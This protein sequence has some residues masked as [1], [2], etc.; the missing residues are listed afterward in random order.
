MVGEGVRKGHNIREGG[1]VKLQLK[2]DIERFIHGGLNLGQGGWMDR[3]DMRKGMVV[4]IIVSG[5]VQFTKKRDCQKTRLGS[6]NLFEKPR[7]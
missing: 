2:V 7:Q 5:Q 3:W 4:G 6:E 1:T